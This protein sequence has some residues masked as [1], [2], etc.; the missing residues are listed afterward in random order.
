MTM[1]YIWQLAIVAKKWKLL[2]KKSSSYFRGI[3][4]VIVAAVVCS[5]NSES[6]TL[7]YSIAWNNWESRSKEWGSPN[8]IPGEQ[9]AASSSSSAETFL[10]FLVTG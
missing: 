8:M 5:F 2:T 1:L 10:T 3:S 7:R 9:V 4:N 6:W